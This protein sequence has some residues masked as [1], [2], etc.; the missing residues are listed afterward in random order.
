LICI[1]SGDHRARLKARRDE[2][3]VAHA[4]RI[5]ALARR[6][7][8]FL[9]PSF[10]FDDL[11]SAGLLE[12]VRSADRYR[13]EQHNG[14]PFWAY[15]QQRIRGAILDSVSDRHYR[16]N[17]LPPL[18]ALERELADETEVQETL[19]H[20][21]RIA[22][23]ADA[24]GYLDADARRLVALYYSPAEPSLAQCGRVLGF[25]EATA[26]RVRARAIEQLQ[27]ILHVA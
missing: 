9:P 26:S 6:V 3:V 5:P 15:A 27:N 12:L 8:A 1:N 21:T 14:T 25:S 2:L 24:M 7:H 19:D 22:R 20:R 10:A 16:A 18:S 23:V 17:T 13:P 4:D 11:V